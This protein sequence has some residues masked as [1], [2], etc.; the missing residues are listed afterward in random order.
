M[1]SSFP[2][3]AGPRLAGEPR[4]D[5]AAQAIASLRGYAYQLYASALAWLDLAPGQELHLEVAKD[6]AT[7]A[8]DALN[9]VEV[10]DT[11]ATI[12]INLQDVRDTIDSFVDL[13][14]RNPDRNVNLQFLSTSSIGQERSSSHRIGSEGA[15]I[16]WRRAAAGADVAP[17][18]QVLSQL[19]LTPRARAYIDTR[20]DPA[21]R[22]DLLQ[23]VHWHCGRPDLDALKS[24]F[25]SALVTYG[26]ERLRLPPA[27]CERLSAIVLQHILATVVKPLP[28]RLIASDLLS[29][30]DEATRV[31][32]P[33]GAV[34]DLIRG[35][36]NQLAEHAGAVETSV[37]GKLHVLDPEREIPFPASF[38]ER[39]GLVDDIL[40]RATRSGIAFVT[41]ATGVGKTM[42]ARLSARLQGGS[43]YLVD[44]RDGSAVEAIERIQHAIADLSSLGPNGV[45][46]DDLN[47]LE[48]PRVRRSL[49]RFI[50]AM[51]RRDGLCLV[52][53]YRQPSRRALSE[54][55][56]DSST[57]VPVP[58]MTIAEVGELVTAAGGDAAIWAR[59]IHLGA[60]FGHPQLVQAM[61]AGLRSRAWP[62]EELRRL[63]DLNPAEEVE[64]EQRLARQRLVAALPDNARS[65]LYR[66]SL[67]IGRFNRSL[68]LE[69]AGLPPSVRNPGEQLDSLV[70]PWVDQAAQDELRISP[71]LAN[72]GT[73]VLSPDEQRAV[74]HAVANVILEP[75]ELDITK[76]NAAFLHGLLGKSEFALTKFGN[77]ILVAK[78]SVRR[79][80][81]DWMTGLRLHRTDR[82][83]YPDKPS[84]SC[85]LRLGQLLLLLEK[86][87]LQRIGKCWS[88]LK[89]E[90]QQEPNA[91][92]KERFELIVLSK[93]LIHS[94]LSRA[95]PDW[96]EAILRFE[97]LCDRRPEGRQLLASINERVNGK[98]SPKP[99]G[100]FFIT[101]VLGL[102]TVAELGAAFDRLDQATPEQR[103]KLFADVPTMPSDFSLLVNHA[104]LEEHRQGNIDWLNCAQ[105]YTRMAEQARSW[106]YRELA[107]RCHVACGVMFD[108]YGSE[109]DR[110][111][112]ALEEAARLLGPDP[113]LSRARAKILYRRKDH[114]G[115][116]KLLTETADKT[117]LNDPIE[118]AHMQ[119]EAGISAAELG[120]WGE[121]HKWFAAARESAGEVG[122]EEMRPMAIGLRAD[123][124][125]AAFRDNNPSI[126]LLGMDQVLE[127]LDAIDADQ[128]IKAVYCRR[129]VGHTVLW[130]YGQA[131]GQRVSI[132]GEPFGMVPGMCSNSE[133]PDL[134]DLPLT[135]RDYLRYLL[136][137]TEV[138]ANAA[139]GLV[140][141]LRTRLRGRAIPAMEIP[142]RNA[143]LAR[144]IAHS[145][146]S[147]F[148]SH[149]RSWIEADL[150]LKAN[151][152]ALVPGGPRVLPTGK[153]SV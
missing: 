119:R 68:I 73:E 45:I 100:M 5:P 71:L 85:L 32:L 62:K 36:T 115:A 56:F 111:L 67:L 47:E 61:I 121:A 150:Y 118:R 19:D 25:E 57:L 31:S 52:T 142:L 63:K 77:S 59:W 136:A 3:S 152:K 88:A 34:D 16:Y 113:I 12:T 81:P 104:W 2:Y 126:A 92:A 37:P 124:A 120:A 80:L 93:V 108:E 1:P 123:E 146:P 95:V 131:T 28:R 14:E 76:A 26:S 44:F 98:A 137:E 153:S 125:I 94:T 135:S 109:D 23:R 49:N 21:L 139:S 91:R 110:A 42:L 48:D 102:A 51:R 46:L 97:E 132:D 13:V 112:D 106:G 22:K 117:A 58:D 20:D 10:K 145:D 55:G 15:L 6:Y 134:R 105:R 138:A 143:Q 75:R 122:G 141:G 144:A 9:A 148:I 107:L 54:L 29:L 127:E 140:L 8:E 116:L 87:D 99:V 53:A 103:E 86:K 50:L 41:G 74:H 11:R 69:V 89:E 84:L 4:G 151:N 24:E 133:P 7:V 147:S 33:R 27:E 149:M 70:G 35:L 38:A 17:L 90:I 40:G 66:M 78:P 30:L 64:F 130:L 129:V 39:A 96:I 65:L 79:M 114:A 43:W 60:A 18:R 82:P 101:Q 128:S 83:I 72:A